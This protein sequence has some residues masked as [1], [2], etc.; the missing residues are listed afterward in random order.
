MIFR[1]TVSIEDLGARD[2]AADNA[3]ALSEA[4]ERRRPEAGA[5][6]GASLEEGLLEAT[7]SVSAFSIGR[8]VRKAQEIFLDAAIDS[9]LEPSPIKSIDFEI[10]LERRRRLRLPRR[11]RRSGGDSSWSMPR[12]AH[13]AF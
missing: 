5:A 2:V 9:A 1:F 13:S 6:I 12:F 7:F 8:A 11:S 4:F 3:E 10:D